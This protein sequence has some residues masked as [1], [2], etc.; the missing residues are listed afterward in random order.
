MAL[1]KPSLQY[2]FHGGIEVPVGEHHGRNVS[3]RNAT[4][5]KVLAGTSVDNN[6]LTGS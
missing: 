3:T 4:S 5:G 2:P 6:G 1:W